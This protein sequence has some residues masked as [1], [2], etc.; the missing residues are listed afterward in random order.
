MTVSYIWEISKQIFFSALDTTVNATRYILN[1]FKKDTIEQNEST[2]V[3]SEPYNEDSESVRPDVE[4]LVIY[5]MITPV[6]VIDW[7]CFPNLKHLDVTVNDI[8]I[9]DAFVCP[10]L[11]NVSINVTK[12]IEIPLWLYSRPNSKV[13]VNKD[14]LV[15]I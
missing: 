7:K 6:I 10:Y 12:Q 11:I 3:F 5:D 1:V 13:Y 15:N 14:M 4:N 9:S 2:I 8:N